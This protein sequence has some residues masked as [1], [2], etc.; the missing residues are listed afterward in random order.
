MHVNF[1]GK[2]PALGFNSARIHFA[3]S[4][5]GI[6][7][8]HNLSCLYSIFKAMRIDSEHVAKLQMVNS[9]YGAIKNESPAN[10]TQGV[11]ENEQHPGW[12]DLQ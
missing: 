9:L 6:D 3:F 7:N 8:N 1:D 5:L 2:E 4:L 12:N 10:V 11:M